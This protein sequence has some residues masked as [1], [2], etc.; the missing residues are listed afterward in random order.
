MNET[1]ISE[2]ARAIS[3]EMILVNWK[4]YVLLVLL[5]FLATAA[6]NF[7]SAFFRT[8]GTRYATKSDF[9]DL[10]RELEQTTKATESIKQAVSHQ[11]WASRELKVLRR[12]KLEELLHAVYETQHWLDTE[13]DNALYSFEKSDAPD[14]LYKIGIIGGLYFPEI[15]LEVLAFQQAALRYKEW[16]VK[17]KSLTAPLLLVKDVTGYK[18]ALEAASSGYIIAVYQ[19]LLTATSAIEEKAAE[20]MSG[21]LCVVC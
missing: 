12:Q 17:S 2:L 16:T 14:P 13:K 21:V 20:L 8:R 4:Y 3:E 19:P 6:G 1:Q 18:E 9:E 15:K 7:L 10:L 5:V 11:D